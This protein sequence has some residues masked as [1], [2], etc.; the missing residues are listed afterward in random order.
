MASCRWVAAPKPVAPS[1]WPLEAATV[2][3]VAC[4]PIGALCLR[5]LSACVPQ[6]VH[7]RTQTLGQGMKVVLGW[8]EGMADKVTGLQGAQ[9]R[10]A[11]QVQS[12]R[13]EQQFALNA[14]ARETISK[15]KGM[16]STQTMGGAGGAPPPASHGAFGGAKPLSRPT[17]GDQSRGGSG[18]VVLKPPQTAGNFDGAFASAPPGFEIGG[19]FGDGNLGALETAGPLAGPAG[20]ALA[21]AVPHTGVMG[22][23]ALEQL[24]A[25]SPRGATADGSH[26]PFRT[27]AERR[28]HALDVKRQNLVDTRMRPQAAGPPDI[29]EPHPPSQPRPDPSSAFAHGVSPRRLELE[30]QPAL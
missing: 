19:A 4:S 29:T 28:K 15:V 21:G 17:T 23:S 30:G 6:T 16:L 26:P 3:S 1:P 10:M 13:E 2:R 8:V 20:A 11:Q 7:V 5:V 12:S 18:P 9:H 27:E 24:A 14:T 25:D 22:K